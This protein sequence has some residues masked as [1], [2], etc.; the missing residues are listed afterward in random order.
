MK[1]I[2]IAA[3]LV[4]MSATSSFAAA[5]SA[6]LFTAANMGMNV[7][8]DTSLAAIGRLSSKDS[9]GFII[10]TSGYSLITQHQQGTRSFGTAHDGTAIFWTPETKGTGH[11][12]PT[13]ANVQ[14]FATGWTV[15]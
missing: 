5:N 7:V 3:L 1:K 13:N 2:I 12:V 6:V 8:A 11:A 9:L 14:E 4:A 15:M 10:T